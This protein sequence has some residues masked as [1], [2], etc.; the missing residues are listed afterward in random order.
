M[1]TATLN[2]PAEATQGALSR[3]EPPGGDT[4]FDGP[5]QWMLDTQV[6][7]ARPV[8][9]SR[10]DLT[11]RLL[12]DV[13][14]DLERTRIANQNRLRTLTTSPEVSGLG[15]DPD[16]PEAQRLAGLV[17]GLA[18]L[19]KQA[20]AELTRGLRQ[21][22]LGPTVKAMPGVGDKQ[23]ARLL[24]AV[25][26]PYLHG[27]TGQPR[28]VSQL[29]SYAGH[30]DATRRR[31]KGMSQAEVFA[32]GSPE[33]KVRTFL[34]AESVWKAGTREGQP[35][36]DLAAVG[37]ARK[38][39]TEGR[40]HAAECRRCGPSGQPALSGSPWSQ[41]HRH[42]D[43]LRVLGKEVLRRLWLASRDLHT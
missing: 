26:D 8:E 25:G 7:P 27:A 17:D 18:A 6:H 4:I 34:V 23:G 38:A 12:A 31:R 43:A 37:H 11:L 3:V 29:W 42:A 14:D 15:L 30:G 28:Q 13:L 19:E 21:H 40:T 9:P 10:A 24:A 41:A 32:M 1:S 33:A 2:T 5:S 39:T 22:P 20:A 16:A 36:N 35:T